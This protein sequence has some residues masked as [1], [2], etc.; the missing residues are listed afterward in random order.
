MAKQFV[1]LLA[2]VTFVSYVG[3]RVLDR[4]NRLSVLIIAVL[5][6]LA[7]LAV[8]K[9]LGFAKGSGASESTG[10]LALTAATLVPAGVSFYSL[11]AI[12]YLVDIYR[13]VGVLSPSLQSHAL[14]LSFFPIVLA[15][16]IERSR[17]FL[18]QLG[19]LPDMS[20]EG[21]YIGCKTLLW[22]YFCKLAVADNLG[23]IVDR[24]LANHGDASPA[25]IAAA[26]TI[27]SFQIYFDVYGYSLIAIGLARTFGL[28]VSVNF[29]KP[30]LARS[31]AEFWR[32]WHISL[33]QWLRDYVYKPIGGSR[34]GPSLFALA[35][36]VTFLASAVWHGASVN[37][38]LWGAFH[39]IA[40][41]IF[42][43]SA[44]WRSQLTS[45]IRSRQLIAAFNGLSLLLCFATVTLG[46]LFFRVESVPDILSILVKLATWTSPTS[47]LLVSWL[48]P[49]AFAALVVLA[50]AVTFDAS[51]SA[52]AVISTVPRRP[53]DVIRELAF[54]NVVLVALVLLGDLG[55]RGFIYF[56]F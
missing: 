5:L 32:R 28:H 37:F 22:G 4:R 35:V 55:G 41:L 26:L 36:A 51:G 27:F 47:S 10:D 50:V 9:I 6:C 25:A 24:I 21:V 7:P 20:I 46:W 49:Y 43:L 44:P 14:F 52:D 12:A 53:R 2:M 15:G 17:Q 1:I 11:Q 45:R 38:I 3:G 13:R 31:L 23:A 42:G 33:S 29:R 48:N 18:P 56:Q 16:P 19:K 8:F 30:Y 54:V 39:A 40:F 34:N